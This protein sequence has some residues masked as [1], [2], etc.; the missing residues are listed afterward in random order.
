MASI[1]AKAEKFELNLVEQVRSHLSATKC[2]VLSESEIREI[3]GPL[4]KT[5]DVLIEA[6]GLL[7]GGEYVRW[8]DAKCAF[9]NALGIATTNQMKA[10][11]K[12][13]AAEWGRGAF[14]WSEGFSSKCADVC[15]EFAVCV[16]WR[17]VQ[18][19][20]AGEDENDYVFTS[21]GPAELLR[22]IDYRAAITSKAPRNRA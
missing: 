22:G 4:A 15:K 13:Y 8:L 12:K 18:E 6:P 19:E 16:N 10:Q 17:A 2:K 11:G 3:N 21:A 14:V 20:E 1:Q 7:V 5:P 9:G